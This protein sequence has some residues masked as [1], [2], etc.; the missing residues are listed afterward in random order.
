[1][2]RLLIATAVGL[3]VS[4]FGTKFLI[5]WLT[6]RQVAQPIQD[7]GVPMHR[8]TKAGTPTMGGLALVAG[9]VIAYVVSD[10]YNGIYTRSGL[11][12]VFA[13]VGSA[14]VGLLDDWIKVGQERNLGL[15][16]R[17][18][19]GGQ[20]AVATTFAVLMVTLTDVHTEVS[21]TRWDSIGFDLGPVGWCIWAI[22]LLVA[23]SNSVNLTDGLDGLAG[24]ASLFAFATFTAIAF[25][26]FGNPEIYDVPH[27]LD[28][29][30]VAAGG[31]GACAGFLWWNAAPAQIFMGDTGSLALGSGLAA[32]ALALNTHLLLPIVGA[33]FVA[34]TVSVIIQV[35]VFKR[36]GK[37]VFL[38]APV[39]HH[40][41][42]L[43]WPET[44]VIIRF[45]LMAGF[46]AALALGI[47]Y[48]DFLSIPGA[49]E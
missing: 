9:I 21:F 3:L 15:R 18:K 27:A 49:V 1:M 36:T 4:M 38:I 5:N 30:V 47:F 10:L 31:V 19:M 46:A 37:R 17:A 35:A 43:G 45:W 12:V 25:W 6:Q 2:I 7:D 39:H 11:L 34:E 14:A 42:M 24:G 23:T 48:A 13:I 33:L 32:L 20:L 8:E 28:L 41:E 26:M 29:A 40:F 44:R 16:A 22:V